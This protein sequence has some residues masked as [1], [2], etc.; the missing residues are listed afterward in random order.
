MTNP[1]APMPRTLA[2]RMLNKTRSQI[3]FAA[4]LRASAFCARPASLAA[5]SLLADPSHAKTT[6]CDFLV[7]CCC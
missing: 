3:A 7:L 6:E 4:I 2:K 5:R 1:L